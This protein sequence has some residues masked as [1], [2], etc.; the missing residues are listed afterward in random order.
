MEASQ[1]V[2]DTHWEGPEQHPPMGV[3]PAP[4]LQKHS[5]SQYELPGPDPLASVM[6]ICQIHNANTMLDKILTYKIA[7]QKYK[8]S[9]YTY[10]DDSQHHNHKF[11]KLLHCQGFDNQEWWSQEVPE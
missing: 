7:A 4:V 11:Q 10:K 9:E 6:M 2:P 3:A 8:T 1:V 5:P